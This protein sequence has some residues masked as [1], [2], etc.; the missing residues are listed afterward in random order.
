[1]PAWPPALPPSPL[2]QRFRETPPDTA[3]RTGMDAG[4]AKVRRRTT[5]GVRLFQ[6]EYLLSRAQMEAL[7]A[8]YLDDLMGGTLAFD[9]AHPRSGDALSCRF[10]A[11]PAY[12]AVNGEYFRAALEL[13]ALP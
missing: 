3:L 8:F 12:A 2:V 6:L 1:M 11:P 7:D 9:F 4:P 13:E 10:R 5:A